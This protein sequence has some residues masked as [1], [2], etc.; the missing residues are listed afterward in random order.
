MIFCTHRELPWSETRPGRVV[1][2][3]DTEH[4]TVWLADCD[5]C[6]RCG[7]TDREVCWSVADGC[8]ECLR[9]HAQ[10]EHEALDRAWEERV[11]LSEGIEL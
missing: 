7:Q 4:E 5:G 2:D 8:R 6:T 3:P 10:R 9:C 11:A 1:S